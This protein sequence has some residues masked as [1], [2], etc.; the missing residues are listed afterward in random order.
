MSDRPHVSPRF[1]LLGLLSIVLVSCENATAPAGSFRLALHELDVQSSAALDT[2]RLSFAYDIACSVE[3]RAV[4]ALTPSEL[5]V[6][7]RAQ[8]L[9]RNSACVGMAILRREEVTVVPDAPVSQLRIVFRQPEGIDSTRT[10]TAGSQLRLA[11]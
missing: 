1:L 7:V 11:P 4:I 3:Q 2:V 10:V 6:E 8:P 9:P 5:A